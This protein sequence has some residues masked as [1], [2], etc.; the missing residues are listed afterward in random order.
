MKHDRY[1]ITNL[2]R[3]STMYIGYESIKVYGLDPDLG[4]YE[5]CGRERGTLSELL[6]NLRG[7]NKFN[8]TISDKKRKGDRNYTARYYRIPYSFIIETWNYEDARELGL[9]NQNFSIYRQED[10]QGY[11]LFNAGATAVIERLYVIKHLVVD[12]TMPFYYDKKGRPCQLSFNY[13][14]FF[15][16]SKQAVDKQK[17]IYDKCTH[18]ETI[19]ADPR[20]DPN[21]LSD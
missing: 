13:D 4:T 18:I 2:H 5:R 8:I 12:G 14:M 11:L 10:G 9:N 15:S 6:R 16:S 20:F 7:D 3:E 1:Y 17:H 19:F 21:N